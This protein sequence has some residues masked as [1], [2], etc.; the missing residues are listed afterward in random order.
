MVHQIAI[1]YSFSLIV[2]LLLRSLLSGRGSLLASRGS[3]L[4]EFYSRYGYK[5]PMDS[6]HF[7]ASIPLYLPSE[8]FES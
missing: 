2:E 4:S 3:L 6:V 1:L 5:L 7:S 8:S